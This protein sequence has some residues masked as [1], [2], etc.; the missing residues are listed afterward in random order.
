MATEAEHSAA[1]IAFLDTLKAHPQSFGTALVNLPD[2]FTQVGVARRFGGQQRGSGVREGQLFRIVL[3]Q[4]AKDFD[5]A[6]TLR[7]KSAGLENAV[8]TVG[9]DTT[10][11]IEFE[12]ADPIGE[13][14]GRYSGDETWIY[15]I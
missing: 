1:V 9:G 7:A 8:L 6:E 3:R 14:D 11:P 12:S 2:S 13:D 5:N 10:T 15:R 4:V